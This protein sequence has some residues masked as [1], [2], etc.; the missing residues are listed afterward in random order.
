MAYSEFQNVIVPK[1]YMTHI[2]AYFEY[3]NVIVSQGYMT[4]I[5]AYSL[6]SFKT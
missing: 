5:M 2:M 6:K 4:H 1:S 3:Q